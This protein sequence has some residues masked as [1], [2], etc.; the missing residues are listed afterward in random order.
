MKKFYYYSKT[1]LQFIEVKNFKSKIT[2][3]TLLAVIFF[4]IITLTG[5]FLYSSSSGKNSGTLRSENKLLKK[6]IEE[7]STLY[8]SLNT[9]LENLQKKNDLLRISANLPPIS[10]R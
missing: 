7:M 3:Y 2:G 6:K 4:S 10:P 1:K 5:Y 9:E 8:K